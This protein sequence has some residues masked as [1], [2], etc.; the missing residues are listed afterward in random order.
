MSRKVLHDEGRFGKYTCEYD[1]II[2][3]KSLINTTYVPVGRRQRNAIKGHDD[4]Q[5]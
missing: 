5:N 4:D 3:W 1:E 2:E